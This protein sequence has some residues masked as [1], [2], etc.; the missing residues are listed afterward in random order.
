[1][2]LRIFQFCVL[3]AF[4]VL[5]NI[6]CWAESRP[7]STPAPIRFLLSF[8][9]GPSASTNS[10]PTKLVLDTLAK[11][12]VQSGIKVIFFTQT[13]ASYGGGTEQGKKI[14]QREWDEG[15]LLE[16][17]TATP[18]HTNHRYLN[19]QDLQQTLKN[20]IADLTEITGSAPKLV[21]PPYWSYDERTFAAY[22][23]N[24]LHVLLTDLSA[25]D[26]K[27]WGVNFSL[28]KHHNM[29]KQLA[30][31]RDKWSAGELPVVDGCVPIVVTFH[32]VNSYTAN[33]I[34][35]YLQILLQVAAELKMTT[36]TTPFYNNREE[37]ERAA[38]AS[39]LHDT[40][41]KPKLPGI[42]G[43]W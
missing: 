15:H 23:K 32:D 13:R 29:Y 9:D 39:A 11:N 36:T 20:G 16:F 31:L 8:D 18:H 17:H 21:R 5:L 40:S 4:S 1:M 12:S 42:W 22:Q 30:A 7:I 28:T 24:G 37:L 35:E 10:N 27:I 33:H 6:T 26:G 43:W 2:D 41:I 38:L 14:M 19:D 3:V 34:E 25:N